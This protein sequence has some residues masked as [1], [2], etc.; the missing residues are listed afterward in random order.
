VELVPDIFSTSDPPFTFT[1]S[2]TI[3]VTCVLT[4][5][6]IVVNAKDLDLTS[7][8]LVADLNSPVATP[9]PILLGWSY[10]P[11]AQFL[12]LDTVNQLVPSAY[13]IIRA[14]FNGIMRSDGNGLYWDSYTDTDGSTKYIA[15]TQLE[16]IEARTVFPCFDEPDLK[17]TFNI[18]VVSQP[19]SVT[20]SNMPVESTETWANGW[21]AYRFA[22]SPVMST[23]QV[24]TVV[25]DFIYV[26][27]EWQN[28]TTYPVRIY[29]RPQMAGK[30]AFAAK[31]APRIQAWLEQETGI[32]YQ[33]PK[34]DHIA[35]P[36]KNGAMENWGLITYVESLLCVDPQTSAASGIFDVASLISHELAHQWYG[37]LVTCKWWDDIWLNE[38]FATYYNYYPQAALGW[39][40]SEAQQTDG[41][42]GI[43][44]FLEIDQR[45]TSDPIR[46]TIDTV[47]LADYAFSGSTY[48]KGGAMVKMLRSILTYPTFK[49][50]LKNY[51][52]KF[53]YSSA[54]TDDLWAELSA[55]AAVDGI[56]QPDGSALDIKAIMDAWLNQMGYPLLSV[57]RNGDGTASVTS[58]RFLSPR[59][60]TPDAPSNYSYSWNVPITVATPQTVDLDSTPTLYLP[61][62]QTTTTIS[63]VPTTP[64]DWIM[65]NV[66]QTGFYRVDYDSTIRDDIVAQLNRDHSVIPVESR[67]QLIDDSF[68]LT[69]S[70]N[71]PVA[72]A[73]D[74]TLYL[75][76]ELLYNPWNVALKHLLY[77]DSLVYGELWRNL[78]RT[79]LTNQ[80]YPA[81]T[82]LGWNYLDTDSPLQQ[83][84]R[85][86]AIL[87]TCYLGDDDCR[88]KARTQ[89][90]TYL[91]NPDA[92][93]I[94][95]NNLPT[96]LCTGLAEGTGSDWST[97]FNQYLE[98]KLSPIREERYVYLFAMACSS[99]SQWHDRFLSY[100]VQGN[101]ISTR[102]ANTAL[103]YMTQ[104][105]VGLPIVWNYLL[106]T[107]SSVPSFIN[108]LTA[109]QNIANKLSGSSAL[110]EF[111]NFVVRYP[112]KN[113]AEVNG[114]NR[115][116]LTITQNTD[117]LSANADA[118]FNWLDANLPL[119]AKTASRK[120]AFSTLPASPA[121]YWDSFS[122]GE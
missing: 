29:A 97:A 89:Y 42:R 101:L 63:G 33:L 120:M 74:T 19:P 93:S 81:Y 37:N 87:Y 70:L 21:V 31:A 72:A 58:R 110:D 17:A 106:N 16:S 66:K 79:Y 108:K 56:K 5:N 102:D 71:L 36:N 99:D 62:G 112:P 103:T 65:I 46:K 11:S 122:V 32:P 68:T 18:T 50:G 39:E 113:Q 60:Q 121:T 90:A 38:G 13:Y 92:N 28:V 40:T 54:V 23:Y 100:I 111:N 1:G 61:F 44:Q 12:T 75:T 107:W 95:A 14:T 94:N 22:T 57:S 3:Y 10:D 77:I 25:G 49:Q 88:G 45:N 20:L 105:R 116:A 84:T 86:D 117:F 104:S 48:P 98:R 6:Y 59:G 53:S 47:F 91:G 41:R 34:M 109:L 2:V 4:A 69:R 52:I 30:L 15:A 118:L 7:V 73:M 114:F 35:L 24:C 78:Y 8:S 67:A 80:I 26:E 96:V 55:Q 51:L 76:N 115:I 64:G 43:Q 83:F 119:A 9:S 85:R 27:A 82:S